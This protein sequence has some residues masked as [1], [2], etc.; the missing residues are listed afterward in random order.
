MSLRR[1]LISNSFAVVLN[2]VAQAAGSFALSALIART[3]GAYALGQYTLGL[4][5][6]Y[7]FMTIA[8]QGLKVL[9]AR[10]LS[11]KPEQTGLYLGNVTILQFIFCII[12][13]AML[14]GLVFVL[15]YSHD[16]TNVCYVVGLILFPF[17]LSNVT[18]AIFQ[19]KEKL[20]LMTISTVPIY[21]L[22]LGV[23]FLLLRGGHSILT[24]AWV[25]VASEFIVLIIE[26]ILILPMIKPVWRINWEFMWHTTKMARSF[27]AIEGFSIVQTRIQAALLSV[28]AG[29]VVVGLYGAISQLLQP[30]QII[31]HSIIVA[32]FP[33]M[34]KSVEQ[35]MERQKYIVQR[36]IEVLL[37][38]ALPLVVVLVF[39]GPQIL[40]F[41]YGKKGFGD[42]GPALG[43]A[44]LGL[45]GVALVRPLSYLLV[46]NGFQRVNLREVIVTTVITVVVGVPL[47]VLYGLNGAAL[48]YV[49]I[50]CS[51]LIQYTWAVHKRLFKLNLLT[52]IWRPVLVSAVLGAVMI[53]IV[54]H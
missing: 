15:P 28:L 35:G 12:G 39:L 43:I 20:G 30:F 16:T 45:I 31:T 19:A 6:Y 36:I 14:A 47:I 21:I 51:S 11:T 22:R 25:Q 37:L 7:L 29:E 17:S 3:L 44:S 40:I 9:I 52:L 53:I 48:S 13:Y 10:E 49:A 27:M 4:V 18:E 50:Q 23:S 24:V 26:W 8:S 32:V 42:A 33:T 41:I 5:Y 1:R 46:A 38:A 34:T 2:R 54:R